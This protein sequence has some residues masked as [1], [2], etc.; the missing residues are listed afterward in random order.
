MSKGQSKSAP[1][2]AHSE[3]LINK[4]D[5]SNTEQAAEEIKGSDA[6]IDQSVGID[7]QAD[8]KEVEKQISGSDADSAK[9]RP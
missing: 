5:K 1:M 6:D 2:K 3:E 8:I 7:E 9:A 4:D